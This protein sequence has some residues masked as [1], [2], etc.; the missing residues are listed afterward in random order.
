VLAKK[1]F[2]MDK[3]IFY[4]LSGFAFFSNISIAIGNIFLGLTLVTLIFRLC[5]K[6]DD[7][8]AFLQ[9]DRG[10][11]ISVL[12]VIITSGISAAFSGQFTKSMS[13]F[14][15]Y[16]GYRLLG[17]YTVL[18]VVKD[19]SRLLIL[20][21]LVA[22]SFIINTLYVL[23][24]GIQSVPRASGFI[25]TMSAAAFFSM[26]VPLFLLL[27]LIKKE[28]KRKYMV[29]IFFLAAVLAAV[30]NGTRGAWIAIV[31]T[32]FMTAFF[33]MKN[34]KKAILGCLL[35][36][37]FVI[38]GLMF[39]PNVLQ[40]VETIG[41]MNYQSNSERILLWESAYHM[42]E[43]HPVLGI[44]F[45][46]FKEA[47]QMQYISPKA[48][49]PWLGHAHNNVLQMLAEC[50]IFG[51]LAFMGMWIYFSYYSIKG[52]YQ[53]K[54]IVYMFLFIIVNSTLLQGLTEYNLGNS[55]VTKLYWFLIGIAL[56]FINLNQGMVMKE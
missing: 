11:I 44:G 31:I 21:K 26:G 32:S 40:R 47:Y 20:L 42:F 22:T 52:W 51:G 41:Q 9:L 43:D 55:M 39:T 19:K 2:G 3:W 14:G 54:N 48:K 7:L 29:G 30:Y 8:R 4:F 45:G 5:I 34:K 1:V 16:Y 15:D 53:T 36:V 49:E 37:I 13:L 28:K 38:A 6:R 35:A 27:F 33:V 46:N 56:Q 50:G 23:G 18:I 10:I 17:F 12:A 24:Q 25:F